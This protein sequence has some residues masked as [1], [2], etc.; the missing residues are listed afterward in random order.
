MTVHW[1][2]MADCVSEHSDLNDL[3][4]W[5]GNQISSAVLRTSVIICL[6]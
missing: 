3:D 5:H 1:L 2:V 6:I 4:F